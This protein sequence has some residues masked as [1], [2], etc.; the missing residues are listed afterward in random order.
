MIILTSI[1]LCMALFMS[2]RIIGAFILSLVLEKDYESFEPIATSMLWGLFY[3]IT[4]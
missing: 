1:V 4:H 3:W 2:Y